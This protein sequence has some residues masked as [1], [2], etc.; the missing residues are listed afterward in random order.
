MAINNNFY[1]TL[2]EL[3]TL[4]TTGDTNQTV[5]IVDYDSFVDAGRVIADMNITQLK[6]GFLDNLMNKVQLT[7]DTFRSYEPLM[8]DMYKGSTRGGIV[9]ILSHTFYNVRQA[10]FINLQ[11]T[12]DDSMIDFVKPQIEARY[13]VDENAWQLPISITDTQLRAAWRSPEAMDSFIQSIL[14]DVANSNNLH[15]EVN[16]I[17]TVNAL[18]ND[19]V[20][21]ATRVT[22]LNTL[23]QYIDLLAIYNTTV[24]TPLTDA[25]ALQTPEFVRWAVSY[26]NMFKRWMRQPSP[27]LKAGGIQTFTPMRDQKTKISTIFDSAIERS[28]WNLYRTEGAMLSDYE[29]IPYWQNSKEAN[30]VRVKPASGVSSARSNVLAVVYDTYALGE[31]VNL[32]SV[33]SERNNK[34]L[35]TTYYYNYIMRYIRNENANFVVFTLGDR[36]S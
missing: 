11:P 23:G 35:Y 32:E 18:I 16:R 13:Y 14:G 10:P 2:N 24:T 29:V 31:F 26:I 5:G 21:N 33:T 12:S 3:T 25:N 22:T 6:N 15:K 30:T 20:A 19:T 1:Q 27:N 4:Y 7:V 34:K 8:A 36:K 17:N 9:E 28:L